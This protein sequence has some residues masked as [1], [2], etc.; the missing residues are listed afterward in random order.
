[1]SSKEKN[2]EKKKKIDALELSEEEWTRVGLFCNL[3]AVGLFETFILFY[4]SRY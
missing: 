3:L 4:N 2:L 1:M